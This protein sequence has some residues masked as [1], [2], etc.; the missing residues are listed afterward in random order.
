M[1][2]ITKVSDSVWKLSLESNVFFIDGPEKIMIDTGPRGQGTELEMFMGKVVDFKDIKRVL[3]THLHY[4]HMGNFDRFPNATFHA[5]EQEI[6]DWKKDPEGATVDKFT[7]ERF[8]PELTVFPK[9]DW[10]EVVPTP[11]HTAGSVCFWMPKERVLFTGDTLFE[12]NHGRTDLP[13]SIPQKMQESLVKLVGYN[14]RV[15]CTGHDY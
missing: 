13:T 9:L 10:L 14:Y 12:G 1:T 15:L 4:D 3:F 5:S 11:G 6:R 7:A 2:S 8:K